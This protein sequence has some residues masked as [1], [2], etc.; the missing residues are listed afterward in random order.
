MQNVPWHHEV[1][2][3]LVTHIAS[4]N[5]ELYEISA[6]AFPYGTLLIRIVVGSDTIVDE[7]FAFEDLFP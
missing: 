5:I 4:V 3:S 6:T 1:F 2:D 7:K